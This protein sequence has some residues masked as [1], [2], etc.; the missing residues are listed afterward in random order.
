MLDL[1]QPRFLLRHKFS[2][3]LSS[4]T[5][6]PMIQS[7]G[8]KVVQFLSWLLAPMIREILQKEFFEP[9]TKGMEP[10]KPPQEYGLQGTSEVVF[11]QMEEKD[12]YLW[13][14]E[15]TKPEKGYVFY[16]EGMAGHWG[17]LGEPA[18]IGLHI[19]Y[20]EKYNVP[21]ATADAQT[22][23]R[24][25]RIKRIKALQEEG[26][27]VIA[28]HLPGFG[29][30][31]GIKPTEAKY[32]QAIQ[33]LIAWGSEQGIDYT[34]SSIMGASQGGTSAAYMAAELGKCDKPPKSVVL[35][36]T[37]ASVADSV[38]DAE[39][40]PDFIKRLVLA[41]QR[42]TIESPFNTLA[43]VKDIPL[44][45]KIVVVTSDSA[46]NKGGDWVVPNHHARIIA[47]AAKDSFHD[48]AVVE[49]KGEHT[50][51][52][53]KAIAKIFGLEKIIS[54]VEKFGQAIFSVATTR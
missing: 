7:E 41:R 50:T 47:E 37:P 34:K 30:S 25:Y 5:A 29:K 53:P 38:V 33:Q 54:A 20:G 31:E 26:Y 8:N 48:V 44:Q 36:A 12:L 11:G 6:L 49:L 1:D 42:D 10:I 18:L 46:P 16:F 28:V 14:S 23:N 52:D 3:N 21:Y 40:P 17:D 32:R 19:K 4:T 9:T 15:P 24:D 27:G 2:S 39:G 35:V 43:L 51:L 22:E 13:K 45:T